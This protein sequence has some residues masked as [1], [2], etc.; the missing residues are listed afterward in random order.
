MDLKSCG[1]DP[2]SPDHPA[3][4]DIAYDPDF[5]ALQAEIDKMSIASAEITGTDWGKVVALCAT[6]LGTKC[7]HLLVAVYCCVGLART[8][9]LEGV[10]QGANLLA[11]LIRNFWE[12]MFPPKRRM[13]GRLNALHWFMEKMDA[14]F[15]GY[16]PA[17]LP[18]KLLDETKQALL[19]LDE[20]VSQ[21]AEDAPM[22]R[23]LTQYLDRFPRLPDPEPVPTEKPAPAP[24]AVAEDS[25]EALSEKAVPKPSQIPQPQQ[26]PQ[27]GAKPSAPTAMPAI[28]TD[29]D[30]STTDGTEAL[31]AFALKQLHIAGQA[32]AERD[33]TDPRPYQYN[34]MAA[35][36][37]LTT[38]PPAQN[39]TAEMIC[40][41][42]T[43]P[44]QIEQLIKDNEL[45]GA[46]STAESQ[47]AS[48]PYW[49]DLGRLSA[50]SLERMG[51]S[52]RAALEVVRTETARFAARMPGIEN[53]SFAN[54]V[55]FADARTKSWLEDLARKAA[56]QGGGTADPVTEEAE[57]SLD[58]AK[59]LFGEKKTVEALEC[60]QHGLDHAG[61]GRAQLIWRIALTR[62]LVYAD[63][64]DLAAPM[65]HALL[66][67]LDE[68]DLET[69]DQALA[70]KAL[71]AA[72]QA[73]SPKKAEADSETASET[74]N[75]LAAEV[76][77]RIA[78]LNPSQAVR[79]NG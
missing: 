29:A 76:L 51:D 72:Y 15:T 3:G 43:L 33:P 6:I 58:K 63:R 65:A 21:M 73:V 50:E 10:S 28:P 35:W 14:Y 25:Q 24:A 75:T 39:G 41:D 59:K 46:V 17:P 71:S 62:F 44:G 12:D 47:L 79:L 26:P 53:I 11:D 37:G 16:E 38:L 70:L 78:G 45:A 60:L 18:G 2:I 69:W 52:A 61:S 5:E 36:N 13:R 7:K 27:G 40:L 19:D 55:P 34:R 67:I 9:Q 8:R 57:N 56:T 66:H 48:Y 64:L 23:R 42:D 77:A 22:I 20:A 49:L 4:E 74:Q 31:I 54:D 30:P 1:T 68:M 32:I